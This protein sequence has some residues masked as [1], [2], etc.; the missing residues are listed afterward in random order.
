MYVE[1][2]LSTV[3]AYQNQEIDQA[4]QSWSQRYQISYNTKII[5]LRKRVTFDL[6]EYYSLFALTFQHYCFCQFRIVTDLNNK[7]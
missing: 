6:D 5:K 1:F 7:T 3:P 4:L 2:Q